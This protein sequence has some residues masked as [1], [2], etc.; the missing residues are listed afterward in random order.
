M[1]FYFL[2]FLFFFPGYIELCRWSQFGLVSIVSPTGFARVAERWSWA[3]FGSSQS[4]GSAAATFDWFF[5]GYL[6]GH[7]EGG[8]RHPP[9]QGANNK[10]SF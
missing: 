10:L 3:S 6:G 8:K 1:L 9:A 4:H 2:F 7:I 5:Y